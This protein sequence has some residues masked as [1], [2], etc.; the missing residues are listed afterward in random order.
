MKLIPPPPPPPP[1]ETSDHGPFNTWHREIY[2]WGEDGR[3]DPLPM[4][5]NRNF[6]VSNYFADFPIDN[7]DGSAYWV[8]TNNFLLYGGSKSLMGY[9]KHFIN[10]SYVLV[11]YTPSAHVARPPREVGSSWPP[12]GKPGSCSAII[13]AGAFAAAGLA[14]QYWNNTCIANS[15][16][17]FFRWFSCN[18][19]H[20]LDGTIPF[21]MRDNVYLST[22]AGYAMP[23]NGQ[24][25]SLAEAQARGVDLGSSVGNFPTVDDFIK[26]AHDRLGFGQ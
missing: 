13:A 24:K 12:E 26:M 21:P 9:N 6:L 11:D 1:R 22:D 16:A 2:A 4:L 8:E 7:D 20:P 25:W 14:D 3:V 15:S 19:T 5:I 17:K 18:D 10:N 23:C